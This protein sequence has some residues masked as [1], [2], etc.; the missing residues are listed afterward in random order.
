[1]AILSKNETRKRRNK[2]DWSDMG[3]SE[4]TRLM[5]TRYGRIEVLKMEIKEL[6]KLIDQKMR[7]L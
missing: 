7:K 4:L 2:A 5:A 1:M 3:P 6:Q